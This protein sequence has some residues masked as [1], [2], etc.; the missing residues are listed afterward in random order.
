MESAKPSMT[1]SGTTKAPH[2]LLA[3]GVGVKPAYTVDPNP[4]GGGGGDD[5]VSFTS[6]VAT[7]T[8]NGFPN[9]G[10]ANAVQVS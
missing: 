4:A 2:E 10:G 7:L 5:D 6:G 8:A 1:P 3:V 9:M